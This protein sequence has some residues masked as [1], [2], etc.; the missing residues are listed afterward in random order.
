EADGARAG[1]GRL[2][3]RQR[4]RAEHLR[5]RRELDVDLE[6]DDGLVVVDG[7]R[8]ASE[9]SKPITCS[10][11]WAASRMRFSLNAGPAIWKPTGRPSARPA[12]IE[13]AGMPASDM[14][15]VQ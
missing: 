2:A 10:S 8:R 12:G 9:P 4:A 6:A 11:A 3:E 7:H 14:G 5:P 13:T 15:T 1:V